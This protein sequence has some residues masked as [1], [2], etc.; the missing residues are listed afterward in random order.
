MIKRLLIFL[1]MCTT[2]LAARMDM[3]VFDGEDWISLEY[4]GEDKSGENIRC[5]RQGDDWKALITLEYP[6]DV[7]YWTYKIEDDGEFR[8]ALQQFEHY[9]IFYRNGVEWHREPGPEGTYFQRPAYLEGSWTVYHKTK[10][11]HVL[12]QTNYGCGKA[13]HIIADAWD[14][15]GDHIKPRIW[16]D[17]GVYTVSVSQEWLDNA[18]YPVIVNDTWGW[19]AEESTEWVLASTP[20][21]QYAVYLGNP[22]ANGSI[23]HIS[24]YQRAQSNGVL[25]FWAVNGGQPGVAQADTA[26]WA[27]SSQDTLTLET[28][29]MDAP[30]AV[31]TSDDLYIGGFASDTIAIGT[32]QAAGSQSCR[33][34]TAGQ[35]YSSG[36]LGN[37]IGTASSPTYDVTIYATYTPD[38]TGIPIFQHHY[39]R[40]RRQ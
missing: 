36:V 18:E 32:D 4:I 9:E 7:N 23:T 39:M 6:P 35:S 2:L 20:D 21:Q 33:V 19:T 12:G 8:Y 37:W 14:A 22:P 29:A 26:D 38:S 30:Y 24:I 40:L 16:I 28:F 15:A 11:N 13:F 17:S 3:P 34:G 31:T 25:G 5:I 1:F 10:R 27:S